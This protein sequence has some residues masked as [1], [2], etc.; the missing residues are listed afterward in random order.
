MMTGWMWSGLL[1]FATEYKTLGCS[2]D[3]FEYPAEVISVYAVG[4]CKRERLWFVK[5]AP[6]KNFPEV[7]TVLF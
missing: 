1:A 2:N 7:N 5:D 4:N 3:I 6:E